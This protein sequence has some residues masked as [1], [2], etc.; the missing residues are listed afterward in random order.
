M[1]SH[2]WGPEDLAS[3]ADKCSAASVIRGFLYSVFSPKDHMK[4]FCLSYMFGTN[5]QLDVLT[6]ASCYVL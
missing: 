5:I 1:K 4:Q 6:V 3:V 2:D